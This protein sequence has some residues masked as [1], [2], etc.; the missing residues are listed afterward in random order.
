ME[1]GDKVKDLRN[2]LIGKVKEK[3]LDGGEM[4]FYIEYADGPHVSWSEYNHWYRE[5]RHE[6]IT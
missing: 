1:V 3:E 5:G 4:W 6:V 2:G